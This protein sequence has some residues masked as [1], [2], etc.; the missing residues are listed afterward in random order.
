MSKEMESPEY[1]LKV[2][3]L[4]FELLWEELTNNGTDFPLNDKGENGWT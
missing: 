2:I 3:D 4:Q 1:L